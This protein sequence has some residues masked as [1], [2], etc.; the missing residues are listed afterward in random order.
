MYIIK[1]VV[2]YVE[3]GREG[4]RETRMNGLIFVQAR[5]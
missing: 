2:S 4:G 3:G 5:A 1:I